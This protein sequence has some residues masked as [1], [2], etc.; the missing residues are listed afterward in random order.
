MSNLMGLCHYTYAVVATL[1][2]H[3]KP[4]FVLLWG[5]ALGLFLMT[6]FVLFG[7]RL[8]PIAAIFVAVVSLPL[9]LLAGLVVGVIGLKRKGAIARLVLRCLASLGLFV[10]LQLGST[11]AIAHL[12]HGPRLYRSA[13]EKLLPHLEVYRATHGY[14]PRNL[15]ALDGFSRLPID[16]EACEYVRQPDG[17]EFWVMGHSLRASYHYESKTSEWRYVSY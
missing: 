6:L 4:F 12:R 2:R 14:Y 11:F 8:A 5:S 3:R 10:L 13:C 16:S 7:N 17:F 15:S 9:I 1:I